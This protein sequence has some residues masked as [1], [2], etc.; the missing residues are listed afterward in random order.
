MHVLRLLCLPPVFVKLLSNQKKALLP[1]EVWQ[2]VK[3]FSESQ[4]LAQDCFDACKF[5][6]DW[7]VVAS[8]ATAPEKDSFLAFG[9]DSVTKQ[10]SN[11]ALAVWL[12]SQLNTT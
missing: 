4:G 1:H 9:I 3:T 2:V 6:M 12:E 8:Q 5:V 7:C 11:S 10:D